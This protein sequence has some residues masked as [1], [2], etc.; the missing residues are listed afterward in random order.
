MNGDTILIREL[1]SATKNV[2]LTFIVLDVGKPTQTKEG[3]KVRTCKVADKTGSINISAWDKYGDLIQ[4]G[5]ICRLSKGYAQFWKG[6]LTLYTGKGGDICKI[7]EFCF[8][9][10]EVPNMSEPNPEILAKIAEQSQGGGARR[11]PPGLRDTQSTS[12]HQQQNFSQPPPRH[13]PEMPRDPRA[14]MNAPPRPRAPMMGNRGGRM[15]NG[16]RPWNVPG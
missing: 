7:G 8:A 13:A 10:S 4:P 12:D 1:K 2:N 11:S 6:C 15:P 9:F 5:D 3:H 16:N 14:N